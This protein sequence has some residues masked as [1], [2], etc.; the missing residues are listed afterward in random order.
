MSRADDARDDWYDDSDPADD[1]SNEDPRRGRPLALVRPRDVRV[2]LVAPRSFEDAQTIADHLRD[3]AVVLVD[4]RGCDPRL[5]GRMTD[6]CSGLAYALDGSLQDVADDVVLV[7]PDHV[8]VCGEADSGV[9][10]PGF[11]NRV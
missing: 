11:F 3:D 9:R 5:A 8:D 2:A 4:L 1:V 7:T 10:P 6:F